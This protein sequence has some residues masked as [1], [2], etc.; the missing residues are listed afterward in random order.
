MEI[1]LER[2]G[3]GADSTLG[4]LYAPGLR[5]PVYTLEDQFR[6]G[7]KVPDETCI[8]DGTFEIK[9]RTIGGFHQRYSERFAGLHRGMLWLQD[10]PDFKYILIHC[11]N[12]ASGPD[13]DTAGCILV[14]TEPLINRKGEFEIRGG[15]SVEGYRM[16]Y[17]VI[18][19]ALDAGDEVKIRIY[20]RTVDVS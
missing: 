11:G 14:G 4:R 17:P 6:N 10:V 13:D 9:Y 12:T 16:I 18:A 2:Y 1:V 15:T 3:L 20:R 8:P 19:D 7:P 5:G